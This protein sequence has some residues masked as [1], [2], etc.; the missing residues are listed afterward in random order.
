MDCIHCFLWIITSG[1]FTVLTNILW[2]TI[3]IVSPDYRIGQ[4]RCSK[5]LQLCAIRTLIVPLIIL[6]VQ[7]LRITFRIILHIYYKYIQYPP[8]NAGSSF[9]SSDPARCYFDNVWSHRHYICVVLSGLLVVCCL[10]TDCI[11]CYKYII[12]SGYFVYSHNSVWHYAQLPILIVSLNSWI[13]ADK[14]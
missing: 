5:R 10:T 9:F 14:M 1:Y 4:A 13:W 8:H 12:P 7:S 3:Q 6:V 11:H 2:Y